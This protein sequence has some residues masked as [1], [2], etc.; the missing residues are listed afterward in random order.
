MRSPR[1]G[2]SKGGGRRVGAHNFRALFPSHAPNFG[3]LLLSGGLV[4][5]MAAQN[6]RLGFSGSFGATMALNRSHNSTKRPTEREKKERNF[7]SGDGQSDILG[8]F[9]EVWSGKIKKNIHLHQKI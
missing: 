6:A 5:G 8:G 1:R 3:F 2:W 9:A 7:A 4:L